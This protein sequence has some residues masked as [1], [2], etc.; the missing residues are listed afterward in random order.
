MAVNGSCNE[1]GGVSR[2]KQLGKDSIIYGIGGL[3]GKGI[4]FFLLPVY[5]RVFTPADYG[6]IEMM[7]VIVSLLTALLVMGMDSAQSFYFFEQKEK[8]L[9]SQKIVVS[10]ILQW[11]LTFGLGMVLLATA[12]APLIN[13]WFF[14]GGL[15]WVY[16]GVSF[17]GALFTAIMGQSVEVF[18]LLYRPWPYIWVTIAH[19]VL[20]AGLVLFCVL[21]LDQGIFG[22]FMG[23][24]LASLIAALLGWYLVCEYLDFSRWHHAWW[25]R[26]LRFGAPLLP[27]GLAFYAMSTADRWFIQHYHGDAAVGIYA[28]GAKFA[29]AMALVIDTFRKAWWPIAMDA[30]HS[31]DGPETF[32]MIARLFM[33]VGV[34]A[35]VYL[36]FLAPWL[37]AWLTSPDFHDASSL[38]GILAWQS[39]FYG[40]YLIASAGIW[41]S[42]STKISM[43]IMGGVALLN[44]VLNWMWVPAMGGMGA[45]LATAISYLIW[46][47]ASIMVS[48]RLWRVDYPIGILS[49]QIALGAS[50][51]A[52]IVYP[53]A[54]FWPTVWVVHIAVIALLASSL[55]RSSWGRLWSKNTLFQRNFLG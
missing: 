45:A 9:S 34:A 35:L 55:D 4:T 26:L 37:I 13:S 25:P 21:V 50:V 38:V 12:M 32:R 53:P 28:V 11:R 27:A 10:A 41:K 6:T 8:G 18:R 23:V 52:W 46:I 48:E 33:G 49:L 7:T 36:T 44:L 51:V 54:S 24:V 20:G 43:Y 14:G 29:L 16:F 17:V 5:T 22:Y 47:A 40:F 31:E 42:E 19:S 30:M 3:L 2:L 1:R 15:T 39:L